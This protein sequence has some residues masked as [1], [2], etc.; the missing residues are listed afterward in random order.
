MAY[1]EIF[2]RVAAREPVEVYGIKYDAYRLEGEMWGQK[3]NFWLDENGVTLKEEGFMGLTTIKSSAARAPRDIEGTGVEDLYEMTA[4][5]VDKMLPDPKKLSYLR[6]AKLNLIT[7]L[8]K[9]L[10]KST[11]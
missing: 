2:I 11:N 5:K 7:R 6:R 1:K 3:V 4:I 10:L 8:K 9:K